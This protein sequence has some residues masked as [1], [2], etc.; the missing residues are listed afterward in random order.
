MEKENLN[1]NYTVV[2]NDTQQWR[3][4]EREITFF[5]TAIRNYYETPTTELL[6]FFINSDQI[7]SLGDVFFLGL[8]DSIENQNISVENLGNINSI[9]TEVTTDKKNRIDL[10]IETDNGV[11]LI[12][13]KVFHKQNNPFQDYENFIRGKFP[14]KQII[15]LILSPDGISEIKDWTGLSYQKLA[16]AIKPILSNASFDKPYNKWQIFALEFLLHIEKYGEK[17]MT[18]ETINFCIENL[19][20]ISELADIRENFYLEIVRVIKEKLQSEIEGF[21]VCD[22]RHTWERTPAFRFAHADWETWSDVVVNVDCYSHPL[23]CNVT[24]YLDTPNQNNLISLSK[25]LIKE[26][27]SKKSSKDWF[28]GKEQDYWGIRW[29]QNFDLKEISNLVA[30]LIDILMQVEKNRQE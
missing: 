21:Q 20:K 14:N 11:I 27:I 13:C 4:P 24:M 23:K 8:I 12:E 16:K 18:E 29:E 15:K 1:K 26:K 22:R 28:E 6:S 30:N 25:T 2:L 5:D 10:L 7:H 17:L 9:H 19:Q 3:K